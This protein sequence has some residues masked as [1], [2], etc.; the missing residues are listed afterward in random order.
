MP[1][2]LYRLT[3]PRPDFPSDLTEAEGAAMERHFGYWGDQISRGAAVVFGPVA[4][5]DGTYG[6]A[7]LRS[8]A[9]RK[10]ERYAP[11]IRQ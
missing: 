9:S 5:P 4:D 11:A 1:I 8:P 10:Q 7:I 6:I 3:P 2:F